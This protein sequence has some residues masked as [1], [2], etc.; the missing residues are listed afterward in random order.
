M[1]AIYKLFPVL[2]GKGSIKLL[3][4]VW[5]CQHT[6]FIIPT[7]ESKEENCFLCSPLHTRSVFHIFFLLCLELLNR[8]EFSWKNYYSGAAVLTIAL[9]LPLPLSFF[10]E[11][12]ML[13]FTQ[14]LLSE[15]VDGWD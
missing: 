15:F 4:I 14:E 7:Q 12:G 11:A 5:R 3:K 13:D 9:I 10:G 8:K 1:L 6:R 2:C